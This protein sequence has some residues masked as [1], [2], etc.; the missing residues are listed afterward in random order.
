MVVVPTEKH[1]SMGYGYSKYDILGYLATIIGLVALAGL[2]VLDHRRRLR[3]EAESAERTSTDSVQGT[4]SVEDADSELETDVS[5]E[6]ADADS[7]AEIEPGADAE[8]RSAEP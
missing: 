7:S 1:V 2:A 5:P 4:D 8:H 3:D 6:D